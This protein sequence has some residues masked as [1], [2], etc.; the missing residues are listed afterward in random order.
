M[1]KNYFTRNFSTLILCLG[2]FTSAFAQIVPGGVFVLNEGGAGSDNASVSFLVPGQPNAITNLYT[3]ANPGATLG[4]VAQSMS[5]N[6]DYAYI[7]LNVSNAVKVV[8]RNTFELV[9]TVNTG[10]NNPRYMAF[11]NGKGYITNWGGA[12]ATD[13]YIAILDLET[14]TLTGTIPVEMGVERILTYNGKLYAAH[15]GGF[16]YNNL[17][18]VIDPETNTV[19][20]TVEVG[21]IPNRMIIRD[22]FLYVICSGNP[23]WAPTETDGSLVKIDL[24]DN[25][26][27]E[28][29]TYAGMHP[30]N[31][32][33]DTEG[34]FYFTSDADIFKASLTTPAVYNEIASLS[35]QG[36]Y[37][38]YGMDMIDNKLYVAD[39]GNYVSPGTA[40]IY[41]TT[42]A[43]LDSYEVGVIPNSFYKAESTMGT[44][45]HNKAQFALYP[46]PAKERFYLDMDS[47]DIAI[48]DI[49][50]KEVLKGHYTASGISV[51]NLPLGMYMV[52]IVGEA[53]TAVKKLIVE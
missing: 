52:K 19:E 14:N 21:D 24:A 47:A 49:T 25:A 45:G 46:N 37:G 9:A 36:A 53:G 26:I 11:H 48:Y 10:L 38:I 28:T 12:S 50:G 13:D 32:N 5:F 20:E 34:N 18:S 41:N 17:L 30:S 8:N 2:I 40:Y 31:L 22:G 42:G 1:S 3:A 29:T 16:D 23:M 39:A 44:P 51:S 7:V 35:A 33:I 27:V 43:L 4:N 15:P 6:G